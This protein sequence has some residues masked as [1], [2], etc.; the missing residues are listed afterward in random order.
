MDWY[1]YALYAFFIAVLAFALD[2]VFG[3]PPNRVHPVAWMGRFIG[4]IDKH[5]KRTSQ[6]AD[7]LRG[8]FLALAPIFCFTIVFTF[9]LALLREYVNAIVWALACAVLLKLVFTVR[10]MERHTR[11]II[12]AI[13]RDDL[14]AARAASAM[15][16]G[17]DVTQLD[18]EHIISCAAESTAE[19]TADGAF[20]P[21]FFLAFFGIPGAIFY[22]VCNT[23]DSMVGYKKPKWIDVGRFSAKLDD[24]VNWI[25]ARLSLPF[26]LAGLAVTGND[27]RE[28]WRMSKKYRHSA[29]S[30]NKGWTMAAYAGGLGI[31]YEKVG[32]YQMGDGPLPTD[33]KVIKRTAD[34]LLASTLIFFLVFVLPLFMFLGIQVQLILENVLTGWF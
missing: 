31:R 14:E 34:V 15:I 28:G 22:R 11:P 3:D 27:W 18:R 4:F 20:S 16:V 21:L 23:L 13:E 32:Y 25:P 7:R 12:A 8:I 19:S 9:L 29:A 26:V 33:P 17:R 5:L 24:A 30:P 6:R 1:L 2:L 10:T